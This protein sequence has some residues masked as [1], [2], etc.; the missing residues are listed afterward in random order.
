MADEPLNPANLVGLTSAELDELDRLRHTLGQ[1]VF[2]EI[3]RTAW[4]LEKPQ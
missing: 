1:S 3:Q 4:K 2:D